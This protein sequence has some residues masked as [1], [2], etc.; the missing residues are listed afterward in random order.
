MQGLAPRAAAARLLTDILQRGAGLEDAFETSCRKGLLEGAD[1]RDRALA[2]AILTTALRRKG[3]IDD[4]L[5]KFVR[6]APGGMASSI[7]VTAAAQILFMRVPHRAAIDLAVETAK[8]QSASGL[9]GLINAALRRLSEN[10]DSIIAPKPKPGI[11]APRWLFS[12]WQRNYGTELAREIALAHLNEA[13]LDISVKNSP[14]EWAE[15]L[16]AEQLPNGTLR[17]TSHEGR[18][19]ELPGYTQGAWWIQDQAASLPAKLLGDVTGLRV[20][21]ICAAPGGK[22]AQLASQGAK[23]TAIDDSERRMERLASNLERLHLT[24]NLIVADAREFT[25]PERFD[26]VLLD[27]P[28]SATGTLRRHPDI[29]WHRSEAQ[30]RELAKLQSEMLTHA[31]SLVKPGGMLVF[32]TCSLEPEEGEAHLSNLPEGLQFDPVRLEELPDPQLWKSPGI[33][34]SLPQ[35]GVDGFFACRFRCQ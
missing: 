4:A 2:R 13:P 7:L 22:T 14:E 8:T 6:R 33:L 21:D 26:A 35:F 15:K 34:R 18:I 11:D 23:V 25:S 1:A 12:R 16:G 19:E 28:C 31:A 32:S 27:A 17:L 30:I 9:A 24:A 3:F 5:S 10:A 20:L 29:A